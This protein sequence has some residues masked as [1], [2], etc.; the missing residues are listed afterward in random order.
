MLTQCVWTKLPGGGVYCEV[1][2]PNASLAVPYPAPRT[3]T[4]SSD[5]SPAPYQAQMTPPGFGPGTELHK[6]IRRW[7]GAWEFPGCQCAARMAQMDLWGPAGCREHLE[8]I[9]GWLL[10]AAG[11]LAEA[12]RRQQARLAAPDYDAAA[13]TI[14]R[15]S[16]SALVW[17]RLAKLPGATAFL[18]R[19]I[20]RAIRRAERQAQDRARQEERRD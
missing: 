9:V 1:C 12:Y 13:D 7:T 14:P 20:Q 16:R 2:D 10:Q 5:S 18:R 15:L 4:A 17:A 3:C 6:L 19:T 11:D 8:E